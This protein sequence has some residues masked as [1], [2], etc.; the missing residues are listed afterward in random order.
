MKRKLLLV[1]AAATLISSSFAQTSEL[2]KWSVGLKGG[3]ATARG[4]QYSSS[5]FRQGI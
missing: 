2:A 5:V 4:S 1:V 3:V